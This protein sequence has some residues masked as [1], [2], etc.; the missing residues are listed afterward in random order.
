MFF[1][2]DADIAVLAQAYFEA[3]AGAARVV[4]VAGEAGI[5][6]SRLVREFAE[7]VA[8]RLLSGSSIPVAGTE[9]PFG[10]LADLLR[11]VSR[12]ER[13][14]AAVRDSAATAALMPLAP[15]MWDARAEDVVRPGP[16]AVFEATLALLGVVGT[17]EPLIVLIED[18]HWA[19][20]TTWEL[21]A[22]LSRTLTDERVLIVVTLRD[23]EI[24]ATPE[25]RRLF[26]ELSRGDRV[27]RIQ[28][29][30]LEA[31]EIAAQALEV[32]GGHVSP[33]QLQ[34][35]VTR[36]GGNPLFVEAL[37]A[38][39]RHGVPAH[40]DDLLAT[41]VADLPPPTRQ[42]LRA[43]GL[44][45]RE[46]HHE[47]L[48]V[49]T[50]LSDAELEGAL[51]P[52]VDARL[53]VVP[54][55]GET[56]SFR[57]PLFA[58]AAARDALPSERRRLHSR[59]ADALAGDPDLAAIPTRVDGERAV[60][61]LG[62]RRLPEALHAYLTA[63]DIAMQ[64]A[65]GAAYRKLE[66]ALTLWDRVDPADRPPARLRVDLLWEAAEMAEIT[67]AGE[68][69]IDLALE[70][71]QEDGDSISA[72]RLERL[73]RY[74]WAGDRHDDS[75]EVY[76]RAADAVDDADV[77]LDTALA[78]AGLGQAAFLDCRYGPAEDYC[79]RA[80]LMAARLGEPA[81][82][83][84]IHAARVLSAVRSELGFDDEAVALSQ[85]VYDTA[86]AV[87]DPERHL[88]AIYRVMVLAGAG[89]DDDAV[90]LAL[91]A[92]ADTQRAG[93][94]RSFGMY[95]AAMAAESLIRLGRWEEAA[96]VLRQQPSADEAI[97]VS[98]LRLRL[99]HVWLSGRRGDHE[100]CQL[101]VQR[102]TGAPT[103]AYHRL[104][105][106]FRHGEAALDRGDWEAAGNAAAQGRATVTDDD[107]YFVARFTWLHVAARVEQLLDAAAR[108]RPVDSAAEH[109]DLDVEI[110][111]ALQLLQQAGPAPHNHA[112]L[113][114]A[115]AEAG[116]LVPAGGHI[117]WGEIAEIWTRLERPWRA[118]QARL[119]QAESAV[120]AGVAHEAETAVRA[121]YAIGT[122][123][124]GRPVIEAAE[125]LAARARLRLQ[126]PQPTQDP[127]D[128]TA[129]QLGLTSRETEVLS[130]V[131]QGYSNREIGQQLY[132]S[133]K[134][135]SV[136]VS[137]ILRK[138]GVTTRVEAAA[139][140]QRLAA[141]QLS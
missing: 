19:D 6:K 126:A 25:Q 130:L 111:A 108:R 113:K 10:P 23:D 86:V 84:K 91:D 12:D 110:A 24:A 66:Q 37:A 131:A 61:L 112:F 93:L 22:F 65:P 30:P 29:G 48:A 122:E 63:A 104:L 119:R 70:A 128:S 38:D 32:S 74:L 88:A 20:V 102:T 26:A 40:L 49:A 103:D 127:T 73:G 2:R 56:Y 85:Q 57:H 133:G 64:A 125:A 140:A 54:L 4:L 120:A 18:I 123:L 138:L 47:L 35:I 33:E 109:R 13:M 51:R 14:A 52:A 9:I 55:E 101:L 60:H 16:T 80:L 68:R 50:G 92:M 1:G 89:R 98:A 121:A 79:R 99:A 5:G 139:V 116:R 97:A 41:R 95:L 115:A 45:G 76:R 27:R 82:R 21:L 118:A 132:V 81:I 96:T 75:A 105:V 94:Y 43:M 77:S 39:G 141:P 17:E 53:V 7:R 137:N 15:A 8:I 31:E 78:L 117:A 136:H 107:A 124:G 34:D 114:L 28:V 36:S 72:L 100:A 11:A 69:A 90:I 83:V 135:V 67:G 62:A 134:T 106:L 46:T 58:E 71:A 44:V 59:I 129:A 87:D 3:R 42:V